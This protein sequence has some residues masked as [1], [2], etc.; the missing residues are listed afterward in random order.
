MKSET[1]LIHIMRMVK[2]YLGNAVPVYDFVNVLMSIGIGSLVALAIAAI[3]AVLIVALLFTFGST[4]VIDM[5]NF[6]Q[7]AWTL[8]FFD[9]FGISVPVVDVDFDVG[10]V[11]LD[12]VWTWGLGVIFE[13]AHVLL[14]VSNRF[15]IFA[16]MWNVFAIPQ[17]DLFANF[18]LSI[19]ECTGEA[20]KGD[21][22][23]DG[24]VGGFFQRAEQLCH[25]FEQHDEFIGV[26]RC[27]CA[28]H[29]DHGGAAELDA[30]RLASQRGAF[31]GP[32]DAAAHGGT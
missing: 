29:A 22:S 25:D 12:R 10:L 24:T 1:D 4:G 16:P 14:D 20:Y 9:S 21:A 13:A 31:L 17:R 23:I 18:A 2:V 26:R 5:H 32:R 30:Q 28:W 11:L 3:V 7:N 6:F 8:R 19:W 15:V 27:S